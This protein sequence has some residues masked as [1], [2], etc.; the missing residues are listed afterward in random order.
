MKVNIDVEELKFAI[1][2]T[3]LDQ[4]STIKIDDAPIK[5]AWLG[6]DGALHELTHNHVGRVVGNMARNVVQL[7]LTGEIEK[8]PTCEGSGHGLNG[9]C[10]TCRGH[11]EVSGG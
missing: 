3:L 9:C 1:V 2:Q 11:G 10:T 7:V 5:L 8:C 6:V 4:L